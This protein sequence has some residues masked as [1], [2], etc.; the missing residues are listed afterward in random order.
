MLPH[1]E[2][3]RPGRGG[4]RHAGEQRPGERGQGA[5]GDRVPGECERGGEGGQ[6]RRGQSAEHLDR[7]LPARLP[8]GAQQGELRAAAADDEPGAQQHGRGPDRGHAGEHQRQDRVHGAALVLERCQ[9]VER[10]GIEGEPEVRARRAGVEAREGGGE[11]AGVLRFVAG[12]VQRDAEHE[13][14]RLR[15]LAGFH[16]DGDP[17]ERGDL[18]RADHHADL[19]EERALARRLVV[20]R[21]Q[22]RVVGPVGGRGVFGL[23]H[24][25]D[26]E[27]R[28]GGVNDRADPEVE[29]L[30]RLLVHRDVEGRGSVLLNRQAGRERAGGHPVFG[31]AR[32]AVLEIEFGRRAVDHGAQIVAGAYAAPG[33]RG[34]GADAAW[35]GVGEL[36]DLRAHRRRV[37]DQLV[38]RQRVAGQRLPV[39]GGAQHRVRQSARLAQLLL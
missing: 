11:A 30:R 21:G 12:G 8:A 18:V 14:V 22:R 19:P 39:R 26:D 1:R 15:Y 36:A 27:D 9:D 29:P 16:G 28:G 13:R 25:G 20:R 10:A 37:R 31:G 17:S 4:G 33:L 35:D 7:E 5:G 32:T 38:G 24:A 2:Q 6:D 3:R 34:F 23:V